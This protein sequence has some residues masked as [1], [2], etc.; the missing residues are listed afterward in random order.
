M[1]KSRK[2]SGLPT[3]ATSIPVKGGPKVGLPGAGSKKASAPTQSV[4]GVGKGPRPLSKP[5]T[6]KP[7]VGGRG[8]RK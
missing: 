8:K 2:P 1:A 6:P 7:I 4:P 5:K 3:R